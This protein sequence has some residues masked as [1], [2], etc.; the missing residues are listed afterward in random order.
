M[1]FRIL[2]ALDGTPRAERALAYAEA[3][4]R[5]AGGQVKVVKPA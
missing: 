5:A 1:S 2:I 3:L 4:V